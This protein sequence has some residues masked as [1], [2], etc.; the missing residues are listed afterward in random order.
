M[1]VKE[2][3]EKVEWECP[4]CDG[5][6]FRHTLNEIVLCSH[7]GHRWNNYRYEELMDKIL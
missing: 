7:C 1:V 2:L 4:K 6:F 5:K 3:D